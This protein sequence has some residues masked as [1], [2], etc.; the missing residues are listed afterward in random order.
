MD[1]PVGIFCLSFELL[2]YAALKL[3]RV[4]PVE[5]T[6]S[7]T[8]MLYPMLP[9]VFSFWIRSQQTESK[10]C[11]TIYLML[12]KKNTTKCRCFIMNYI[13]WKKLLQ[14]CDFDSQSSF[15][16]VEC[17]L[18]RHPALSKHTLFRTLFKTLKQNKQIKIQP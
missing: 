18:V 6:L 17:L 8:F 13:M 11:C 10:P 3:N 5:G 1:S 14:V 9:F 16:G 15:W 12:S 4:H 7:M 2:P